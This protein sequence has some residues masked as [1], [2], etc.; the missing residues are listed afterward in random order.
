MRRET[1]RGF[2]LIELLVVVAIIGILGAIAIFNYL[3]GLQRAR[4]KRTMADMRSIAQAWETKGAETHGYNA[5]GFTFPGTVVTYAQLNS[6]LVPTY[7]K[8]LPG[9][10]AWSRD[11]GFALDQP[12]GGPTAS[13]YA[14]RSRGADGQF[15]ATYTAGPTNHF[16]CDIVYANGAFVCY[17]EK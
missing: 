14:I 3:A 16:D 15:D 5:A 9:K 11:L 1:R 10:D 13:T 6:L 17:P 8:N 2:T 4:Q 7:T 12:I